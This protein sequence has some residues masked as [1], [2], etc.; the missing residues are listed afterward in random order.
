MKCKYSYGIILR[1]Y[2]IKEKNY[3]YLIVRRRIT[4]SFFEFVYG[5]ININNEN[6]LRKAFG[7]M[8]NNEKIDILYGNYDNLYYKAYLQNPPKNIHYNQL[9]SYDIKKY[10]KNKYMFDN[11]YHKNEGKYIRELIHNSTNNG[12][13]YEIPK[14]RKSNK[15]ET[16]L[17]AAM[18]EF[19]E[20]TGIST[21]FYNI[22]FNIKPIKQS[23]ISNNIK[24]YNTYYVAYTKTQEP[25]KLKFNN[26]QQISEIDEICWLNKNQIKVVDNNNRIIDLIKT[27]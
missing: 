15:N 17:E 13:L 26:N 20:E 16:D 11:L 18:R 24:Y 22:D 8:T 23:Y 2:N 6:I 1:R 14:G 21:N 4:Y 9:E 5:K 12:L 3:Q 7:E 10:L 27:F 25:I 19:L